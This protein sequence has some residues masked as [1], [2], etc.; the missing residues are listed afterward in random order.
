M[1]FNSRVHWLDFD[2]L[3]DGVVDG[4]LVDLLTSKQNS[5]SALTL[6]LQDLDIANAAL[7]PFFGVGIKP[8]GDKNDSLSLFPLLTKC[9]GMVRKWRITK[10]AIRSR[11]FCYGVWYTRAKLAT[12]TSFYLV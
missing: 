5:V 8:R 4:N 10:L 7:F 6:V 1:D 9:F 12:I 11:Q 3:V 2:V